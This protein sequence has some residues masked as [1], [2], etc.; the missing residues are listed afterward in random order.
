MIVRGVSAVTSVF[1]GA[2]SSSA[3]H[4]SSAASR[5]S[6]SNRPEAFERAPRPFVGLGGLSSRGRREA[7]EGPA[8]RVIDGG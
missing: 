8:A 7:M 2:G 3:R 5:A 1:R 4:P 6:G